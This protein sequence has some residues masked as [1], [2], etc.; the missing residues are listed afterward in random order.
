MTTTTHKKGGVGFKRWIVLVLLIAGGVLGFGV[1]GVYKPISPVV[2]IPGEEIW[3]GVA[4]IPGV[5]P[6]TNTM[7]ATL[8]SDV[9]LLLLGFG[10]YRFVKS[11]KLV[12]SGMYNAFEA[13]VEWLWNSTESA[14]GKWAKGIFP[15]VATIF[16]IVFISNLSKLVPGYEAIGWLKEAHTKGYAAVPFGP[17]T[18]LDAN[19][20]LEA[21]HTT[22]TPATDGHAAPE[23]DT[24]AAPA[25]GE[26]AA[27][28]GGCAPDVPCEVVPFLR[29]AATDLNFTF[30]LAITVM[31]MV[32]VFGVRALGI[33]Y[34]TKFINV[35]G[36]IS[37][38]GFG[39]IDFGVGL[40]ELVSEFSKILSFSFRLFGNIFAGTLLLSILGT[41]T[42]IVL[43]PGLYLFEMFFGA[44]QAYVFAM[45]TLV[46]MSQA[47]V[48]HHG[49]EHA[50]AHH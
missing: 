41:L 45:L 32:Q 1:G 43:P 10:A 27:T 4:L 34:F 39:L 49:G 44:I 22:E 19:Q 37:K 11:G 12:P 15:F 13:L 50:E 35:G 14:A 25:E 30:A 7:L 29:G 36:L 48:S 38:P 6:F 18:V 47:T 40:L 16:F 9:L 8:V 26:H 2:V 5:L 24:H 33:G 21:G 3:P 28:T 20:P 46:F 42:V 17:I 31:L 23:G